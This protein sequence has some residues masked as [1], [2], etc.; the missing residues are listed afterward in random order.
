MRE[1]LFKGIG[2]LIL[3]I[4][5]LCG[6]LWMDYQ[7]FRDTPLEVG[8]SGLHLEVEPGSH[9]SSIARELQAKGALTH[10]R[11]LN[12]MARLEGV[13]SRIKTGEYLIAPGTTPPQLLR[14]LSEGKVIQ[15]SLTLVEGWNFYEV[16]QAVEGDPNLKHTLKGLSDAAIMQRLG[17]PGEHPEGRF[18][19]DT[20]YFPR[21]TADVQFLK[22]AYR[23][24]TE[25]L[26]QAWQNRD[27]D[28]PLRTPYEALILASIIEKETGAPEERPEI[29][30]VFVRRLRKHMRLQTDPAVIYGLGRSFDG[31]LRRRDL[32][33]DTP[34]NTYM[35]RGLPPTPI[36]MPG[37]ASIYAALHPAP[38]DA[39]YFVSRG[40]GTHKFSATLKEHDAAVRRYQ[41]N[42]K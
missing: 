15:Y 12:W 17:H 36:A 22:R 38:G 33:H 27:K 4:S 29:A 21:G 14:Q 26:Q 1:L 39:L 3:A 28:L 37:E 42:G 7:A 5:L 32:H 40:D 24:M 25:R 8:K 2:V 31:N 6:W 41:L 10:P 34:Y 20:Y 9:F 18:F 11:Y 23:E 19:P 30:G 13:A 35:H 16:M